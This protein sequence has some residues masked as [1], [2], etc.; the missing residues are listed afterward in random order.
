MG[1]ESGEEGQK[2]I[3]RGG[4]EGNLE[5]R[6]RRQFGVRIVGVPGLIIGKRLKYSPDKSTKEDR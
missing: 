3:W 2:A 4:A 1:R 6:D 5:R